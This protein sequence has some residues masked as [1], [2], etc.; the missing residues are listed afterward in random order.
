MHSPTDTHW[1]LVKRILCYLLGTLNKGL[2]LC[3]DSPYSLFAFSDKLH[4]FSD[5]DWAG[6]KDDYSSTSAYLVYLG[7]NLISWSSKKQT[8]IT[9]SSIEA[10][11]RSV[12]ATV[13]EL[14]WVCSL[15]QE[16]GVALPSSPVIY[17][18]N[19]GATQLSSNPIFHSHMKHVAVDYHFIR[20]QVQSGRLRVAHISSADQL[21]D[22]LTK[23]L[24]T[25]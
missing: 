12:A 7:C 20:D 14:S 19:V 9:R 21:A 2:L 3:R 16:L 24:S 17:Y 18:D 22:L 8:T 4:A 13:P 23:P 5:A 11:Y 25:S 10:E 6:N 15:I 1:I